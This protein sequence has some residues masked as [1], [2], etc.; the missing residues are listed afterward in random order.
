MSASAFSMHFEGEALAEQQ[1]NRYHVKLKFQ[2]YN[3]SSAIQSTTYST[4]QKY[5]LGCSALLS[6]RTLKSYLSSCISFLLCPSK[7]S[8]RA[9]TAHSLYDLQPA[10]PSWILQSLVIS[11]RWL[12]PHLHNHY[13]YPVS[14]SEMLGLSWKGIDCTE[15]VHNSSSNR[16]FLVALGIWF[17]PF[18]YTR[19]GDISNLTVDGDRN[20]N[21]KNLQPPKSGTANFIKEL[22]LFWCIT[23][24]PHQIFR[25]LLAE[26]N[27]IKAMRN[28]TYLQ[29]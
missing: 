28:H 15:L 3:G 4:A 5:M 11:L 20:A 25:G 10:G 18:F 23:C 29:K 26:H 16:H 1:L 13:T 8:P 17:L 22:F 27:L 21:Q 24:C 7:P 19:N 6:H 12:V 14:D 9:I 2:L